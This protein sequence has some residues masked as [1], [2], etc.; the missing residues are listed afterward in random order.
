MLIPSRRHTKEDLELWRDYAEMDAINASR[1]QLQRKVVESLAVIREFTA[2]GRAYAGVSWGKDSVV[3]AHLLWRLKQDIHLWNLR[4][5]SVRN[6]Y[7]DEV[8]DSFLSK[9]PFQTYS[10]KMVDYSTVPPREEIGFLEWE[11]GTYKIWDKAWVA[12]NQE[13]GE[14]YISGVRMEE[15]SARTLRFY[16]HGFSSK[17]TCAPLS[18]WKT[19]EVFAYLALHDLPVHP[20]YAMLG[21]G[22]WKREQIRVAEI[23]DYKGTQFGRAEWEK[24]YYPEARGI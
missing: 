13:S 14:R 6:P 12:V 23:G 11:K 19:D 17:N 15:S 5:A 1:P 7:C 16:I 20:N 2:Q 24:E 18:K 3:I 8:R 22:R 9:F 4:V 10:E 21:G